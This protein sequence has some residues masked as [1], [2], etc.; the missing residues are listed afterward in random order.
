MTA[1]QVY[2]ATADGSTRVFLL[3][4]TGWTF[5]TVRERG[6]TEFMLGPDYEILN[7]AGEYG[8]DY[9]VFRTAP[10]AGLI[11]EIDFVDGSYIH[12]LDQLDVTVGVADPYISLEAL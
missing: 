1:D 9:L 6:G 8:L 11:V 3:P 7:A 10:A 2:I 12:L 4:V 5:L